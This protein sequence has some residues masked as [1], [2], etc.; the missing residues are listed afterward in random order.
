MIQKISGFQEFDAAEQSLFEKWKSIASDHFCL[1]G[2][3]CLETPAVERIETL[4]CKGNDHEIYTLGRLGSQES[5]QLGLRFDLTVPM[6]RHVV[7]RQGQIVFPYRRYQ[8]APVWRGERPQEGR[9][10][11]FY[12]CDVDIVG[13][14]HLDLAY[15]G[16]VVAILDSLLGRLQIGQVLGD[17]RWRINHRGIL[18]AWAQFAG[19]SVEQEA[20]AFRLIDKLGKVPVAEILGQL[21]ELGASEKGLEVL[22]QWSSWASQ[23]RPSAENA[24]AGLADLDWGPLLVT[25]SEDLRRV[26]KT[27]VA[28]GVDSD[29]LIFD[30]WLARGLGYYSGLVFEADLPDNPGLGSICAGGRYGHLAESLSA[31]SVFPGVGGS[32]GLSRLFSAYIKVAPPQTAM[33]DALVVVWQEDAV[34]DQSSDDQSCQ[35]ATIKLIPSLS[36]HQGPSSQDFSVQLASRLRA[37]GLR[38]EVFWQAGD[39]GKALKYAASKGMVWVCFA[40][41][42]EQSMGQVQVRTLKTGAQILVSVDQAVAMLNGD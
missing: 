15:D 40:N 18:Q 31:K 24:L 28:L 38:T 23:P 12:Q 4:V 2:F 26:L 17:V 41:S 29:R 3:C 20:A 34:A 10:R 33:A 30:P 5:T 22:N 36:R 39:L 19:L 27:M 9:Y 42:Q 11:Q 8:I 7:Q 14:G 13:R 16:E 1:Y 37:S 6:A 32:I 35:N 21:A 25:A